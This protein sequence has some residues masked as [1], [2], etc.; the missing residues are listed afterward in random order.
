MILT[1]DQLPQLVPLIK[2]AAVDTFLPHLVTYMPQ[3]DISTVQ[4]IGGFIAQ[5]A[6]ESAN[7]TA[8]IEKASGS[9]Y[10]GSERLGNIYPGDGPKFKGRGLIQITGRNNY[11][12]C[13]KALFQDLRLLDN[14]D[15]LATPQYAVMS[16]CWYWQG[17]KLNEVCDEPE[18]W[19][20]PGEHHYTKIQWMTVE[21]NGG[22]NG[23]AGR[24]ANYQR[25]RQVLNF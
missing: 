17:W 12:S 11:T 22:L 16:A 9:L 7:F 4:R 8:V 20:H 23:I 18:E 25:A 2:P 3:F 1:A 13:S 24:V 15:I 19:T 6:W 14:P 21:I 10:E 5:V